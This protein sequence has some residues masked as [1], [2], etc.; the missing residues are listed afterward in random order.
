MPSLAGEPSSRFCKALA[1]QLPDDLVRL[2]GV[3]AFPTAARSTSRLDAMIRDL[4]AVV[5][6]SGAGAVRARVLDVPGQ[7]VAI[8]YAGSSPGAGLASDS[9]RRLR[10]LSRTSADTLRTGLRWHCWRWTG[11]LHGDVR[12][13]AVGFANPE[14]GRAVRRVHAACCEP[15]AHRAIW[16]A[17][18]AYDVDAVCCPRSLS[19]RWSFTTRTTG[20]SW[21]QW[22][23][24]LAARNPRCTPRDHRRHYVCPCV[25]DS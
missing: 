24:A 9:D 11:A 23:S 16:K 19:P 15:E 14:F 25:P 2:T 21:P 1:S 20:C 6:R 5:E 10:K 3:R 12:S 8:A 13:G 7:S 18:R 22:L 4:E 17:W